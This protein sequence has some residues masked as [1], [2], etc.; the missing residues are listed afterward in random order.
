MSKKANKIHILNCLSITEDSAKQVLAYAANSKIENKIKQMPFHLK[1]SDWVA[2]LFS[3]Q[4]QAVFIDAKNYAFLERF[5]QDINNLNISIFVFS[6]NKI[7]R[8]HV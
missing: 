1:E 2:E 6:S 8:A 4:Y 7:G 5:K 3:E